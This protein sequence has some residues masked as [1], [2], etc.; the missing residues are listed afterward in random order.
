MRFLKSYS[1]FEE[2]A[3]AL[4][5]PQAESSAKLRHVV[6]FDFDGVLHKSIF[7][8]TIHPLPNEIEYE[9]SLKM[10]KKLREE[11]EKNRILV[12][13]ARDH[14]DKI[15]EFVKKYDLPV[16]EVIV[17]AMMPK[18]PFFKKHNVIRHYDDN[19]E[20]IPQMKGSGIELVLVNPDDE[21][22]KIYEQQTKSS[23]IITLRNPEF[24]ISPNTI[25]SFI[26]Q[27]RRL[28]R[29]L[30]YDE[31]HN[32]VTGDRKGKLVYIKSELPTN[33]IRELANEF[34]QKYD[35]LTIDVQKT[36]R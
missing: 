27:L 34:I 33:D 3:N 20:L 30:I 12:I 14:S 16:D 7:P 10:H 6:S 22:E 23:F 8:G 28:D 19:K 25:K 9:P 21:T 26:N 35:H 5:P 4:L 1:L 13:S 31:K 17:T 11:A 15:W 36:L 29:D 18:L 24:Y 32:G 2:W